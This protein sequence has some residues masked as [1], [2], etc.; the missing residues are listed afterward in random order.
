M[1]NQVDAET[2][3]KGALDITFKQYRGGRAT[4]ISLLNAQ[5]QYETAIISRI[6][7]QALRYTDSANLFQVLGGGWWNRSCEIGE[8]RFCTDDCGI[9]PGYL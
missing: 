1:K 5:R 6:Q 8:T 7:A 4:Y 2:A 9:F 3:A